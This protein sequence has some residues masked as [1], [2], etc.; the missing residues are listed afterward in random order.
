MKRYSTMTNT[1]I[2]K[3]NDAAAVNIYLYVLDLLRHLDQ[4]V[5]YPQAIFIATKVMAL[6]LKELAVNDTKGE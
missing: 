1:L 3:R 6:I 5:P 2:E 4:A